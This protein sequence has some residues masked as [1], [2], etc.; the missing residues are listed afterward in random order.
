MNPGRYLVAPEQQHTQER[1]FE[2]KGGN[3]FI[4]QHRPQEVGGRLGKVAPVGAEL[5]GHHNARHHAHA[6]HHREHLGPKGRE[7]C[8]GRVVGFKRQ[9]LEHCNVGRKPDGK[10]RKDSVEGHHERKLDSRQKDGIKFHAE[11]PDTTVNRIN[12]LG[13]RLAAALAGL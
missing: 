2:E 4:T 11:P 3:H 13:A 12:E 7:F 9:A 5:E 1:R 8:P 10:H 6:K